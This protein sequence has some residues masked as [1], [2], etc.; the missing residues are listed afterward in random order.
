MLKILKSIANDI[1]GKARRYRKVL[2]ISGQINERTLLESCRELSGKKA[3]G[4]D[5]VTKEEY[6]KNLEENI[7]KLSERL[8]RD[9]YNPNPSRRVMIEKQGSSKK[10]PL[11]I[12][13]FE[14]KIVEKTV[15]MLLTAVYETKF[16]DCSFGFR[17]ERNCHQAIRHNNGQESKLH[18]RS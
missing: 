10:R 16:F 11:G 15:A 8:R 6:V 12:S 18:S 4:V 13:C 7:S 17:P 9:S 5:K 1:S 3:V 2:N 14:D